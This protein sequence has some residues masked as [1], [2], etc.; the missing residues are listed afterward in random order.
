MRLSR[1]L[2]VFIFAFAIGGYSQQTGSEKK[3]I[4][5]QGDVV[6]IPITIVRDWPFIDG[7]INGVKGK[8]MFDTGN[9]EAFSVH[10]KKIPGVASEKVG[11]GFVGS[12]QKFDVLNYPVIDEVKVGDKSYKSVKDVRGNNYD[13]L[14]PITPDVIGQIGFKF[15]EG[16]DLKI[17]YLKNELTFYKQKAGVENWKDIKK[18]KNYITSLPYFT[19]KLENHP[20]INVKHKGVDF[21]ATF[22]TGGGQGTFTMEDVNFENFTKNGDLET[23]L[24]DGETL[25]NFKDIKINDRLKVNLHGLYKDDVSPSHVPLQITEKN[26]VSLDHS[27]L[28]QYITIWDTKNKV[29]HVLQKK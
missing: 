7:E 29:I 14:E 12:G 3:T 28:S 8:W 10:S 5:L 20:M 21:L 9:G 4:Y 15:F 27:F 25:Y 24:E 1:L 23:F 2:S 11:S 17:D 6:K 26:T 13:F 22:D 19:R 16:Y 18:D